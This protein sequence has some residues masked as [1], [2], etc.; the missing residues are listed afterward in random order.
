MSNSPVPSVAASALPPGAAVWHLR[1]LGSFD[2]SDGVQRHHK[3][4]TRAAMALLARL[5]LRPDSSHPRETLVELLWPDVAPDAGRQRLRQTLST[6]RQVLEPPSRPGWPV[7]DADRLA[8]RLVPGSIRCDAQAFEAAFQRGAHDD[9]RALYAGELMPGFFDEWIGDE[10][11]RLEGLF[12][13]LRPAKAPPEPTALAAA[14]VA[15]RLVAAGP[16]RS[17]LPAYLTRLI[18]AEAQALALRQA[19]CSHRLVTLTGTGGT[20]KTRLAVEVAKWLSAVD[21]EHEAPLFDLLAF[22]PLA[23]CRRRSQVVDQWLLSLQLGSGASGGVNALVQ[24]LDGRPVLLVL[25]NFEQAVDEA[26]ELVAELMARLPQLHLLV[27]SRR[28]LDL[29]GE[30]LLQAASLP[31]PAAGVPVADAVLNPAVALFVDRAR[32]ARADF[33]V[34]EGNCAAVIDLVQAL[35]GMPLAIELAAARVRSVAPADMAAALRQAR[36]RPVGGARADT[37]ALELLARPPQRGR[38]DARHHSMQDTIDWSWQ[39]LAPALRGLLA[40]L[41]VF[42][43]GFTAQAAQAVC[44]DLS[45]ARGAVL[46]QLDEL[47]SHSLLRATVAQD[48]ADSLRFSL[49]E[50]IREF[51]ART[52]MAVD[53]AALRARHRHWAA[54]WG[55][56][57]AVTPSL[58]ALRA[59]WPNLVAALRSAVADGEPAIA[60]ETALALRPALEDSLLPD[61]AKSVLQG[62]CLACTDPALAIDGQV[63]LGFDLFRSGRGAESRLLLEQGIAQA[64]RGRPDIRARALL[65]IAT[66]DFN[67]VASGTAPLAMLAE[68]RALSVAAGDALLQAHIDRLSGDVVGHRGRDFAQ[69]QALQ[70]GALAV[71]QAHGNRLAVVRC[72]YQ[73][74]QL[75]L[76]AR[77]YE[78]VLAQI[79]PVIAEARQMQ[80]W[81]TLAQ[82]LNLRG[83]ALERLRRWPEACQDLAE[84]LRIAWQSLDTWDMARAMGSLMRPLARDHQPERAVELAGFISVFWVQRF[85]PLHRQ[86]VLGLR[87]VRRLAAAHIGTAASDAGYA[88]GQ[89]MSLA[90]AIR[91]GL[92][93]PPGR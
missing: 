63:L 75:A 89:Q 17:S 67:A 82:A 26:A 24:A 92:P 56:A 10:R 84:A 59:E 20:G 48:D 68:A 19:V 3:L 79:D 61:G 6:L 40:R 49:Y 65:G 81:H 33:H 51:A 32:A 38:Q 55:S 45:A 43:G 28:A 47:L 34:H 25:D 18:G 30:R 22:V 1:L 41:T 83:L 39:L 4:G 11:L 73:M 7:I 35:E 27:T 57:M 58:A 77:H 91:I 5:C 46:L 42:H 76:G 62:A 13:R 60:I 80:A 74:A 16:Q 64:P 12:D 2:L 23:A 93:G 37:G 50:P 8:I 72:T 44:A 71:W 90:Q 36:S 78:G 15:P 9:A 87:R 31:L 88:R 14:D 53:A 69:A 21:A 52:L 86:Q 29:P 54:T 66:L 85:S 70:Q